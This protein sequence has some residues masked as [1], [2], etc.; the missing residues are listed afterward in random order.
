[1]TNPN[2]IAY[3]WGK[4]RATGNTAAALREQSLQNQQF[5]YTSIPTGNPDDTGVVES[6]RWAFCIALDE[7]DHVKRVGRVEVQ[8]AGSLERAVRNWAAGSK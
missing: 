8:G 6:R 3:S 4:D 2:V 1:M 5:G 7:S